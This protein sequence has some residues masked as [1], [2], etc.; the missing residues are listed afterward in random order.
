MRP[1]AD[2][3]SRMSQAPKDRSHRVYNGAVASGPPALVAIG[4]C[5]G[6]RNR[7]TPGLGLARAGL[8]VTESQG[9][10]RRTRRGWLPKNADYAIGNSFPDKGPSRNHISLLWA[11]L[12]WRTDDLPV[13]PRALRKPGSKQA[14]G[15]GGPRSTS[16][17]LGRSTTTDRQRLPT[18]RAPTVCR[19]PGRPQLRRCRGWRGCASRL[20]EGLART[21]SRPTHRTGSATRPGR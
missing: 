15:L 18:S 20:H 1:S 10:P 13:R 14:A 16:G 17:L 11:F 2:A 21:R 7:G 8:E 12:E 5:R 9:E 4:G 6:Q 19:K 3:S